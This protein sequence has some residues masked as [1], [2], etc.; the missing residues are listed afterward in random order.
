MPG[1]R[2]WK[3]GWACAAGQ[4]R[5][6][7]GSLSPGPDVQRAAVQSNRSIHHDR[8]IYVLKLPNPAA[9]ASAP[10]ARLPVAGDVRCAGRPNNV[11]CQR[12]CRR[13]HTHLVRVLEQLAVL[14]CT[15]QVRPLEGHCVDL[16]YQPNTKTIVQIMQT[17]Y[18]PA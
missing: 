5:G 18:F 10:D 15:R 12:V 7:F 4:G 6:I 17:F 8:L 13:V 2:P 14:E 16:S 11:R 1:P 9:P 3:P